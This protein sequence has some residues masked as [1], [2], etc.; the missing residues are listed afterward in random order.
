MFNGLGEFLKGDGLIALSA[1]AVI[2]LIKAWN[3][4]DWSKVASVLIIYGII[5]S[6]IQGQAILSFIGKVLRWFGIE[7][8]L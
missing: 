8:G 7:T 6:V 4:S 3:K 1:L 5:V 2:L